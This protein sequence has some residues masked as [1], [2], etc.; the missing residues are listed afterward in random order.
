[1]CASLLPGE[2]AG[3]RGG[4]WLPWAGGGGCQPLIWKRTV[5]SGVEA[6]GAPARFSRGLRASGPAGTPVSGMLTGARGPGD[7][8]A[9]R[10]RSR[11]LG[12]P[13]PAPQGSA[14]RRPEREEAQRRGRADR[15]LGLCSP[16]TGGE[17]ARLS[18]Q[19]LHRG[20]RCGVCQQGPAGPGV[21]GRGEAL[22]SLSVTKPEQM[23]LRGFPRVQAWNSPAACPPH[24]A[25]PAVFAQVPAPRNSPESSAAGRGA[26]GG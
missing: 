20:R 16:K 26:G 1:M 3:R 5:L 22:L 9:G 13:L 18:E 24:R 19:G 7:P 17:P 6:G 15:V 4:S 14:S 25:G 8:L 21:P 11:L 23:A 10:L 2:L 12:E